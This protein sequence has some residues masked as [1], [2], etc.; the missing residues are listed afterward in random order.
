MK[1]KPLR[2]KLGRKLSTYTFWEAVTPISEFTVSVSK[3]DDDEPV[4]VSYMAFQNGTEHGIGYSDRR[5]FLTA[6]DA[7]MYAE[8]SHAKHVAKMLKKLVAE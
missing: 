5:K 3:P 6:D 1:I 8:K 7:M 2:W 4:V